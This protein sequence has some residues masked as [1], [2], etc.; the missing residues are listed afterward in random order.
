MKTE[1]NIDFKEGKRVQKRPIWADFRIPVV[2]VKTAVCTLP[3]PPVKQLHKLYCTSV[4]QSA[5]IMNWHKLVGASPK[6]KGL[7]S[8]APVSWRA[9]VKE[10][11]HSCSTGAPL[12]LCSHPAGCGTDSDRAQPPLIILALCLKSH[13]CIDH[14][15]SLKKPKRKQETGN[16]K[17]CTRCGLIIS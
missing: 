16:T 1:Q 13:C 15:A 2:K 8:Q 5:N 10:A 6:E 3:P 14:K 7:S 4:L 17:P 9:P 12:R 11:D